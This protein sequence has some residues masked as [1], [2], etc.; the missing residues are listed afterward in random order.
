MGK[1]LMFRKTLVSQCWLILC[2]LIFS[3]SSLGEMVELSSTRLD[4]I[5]SK[6]IIYSE[7]GMSN[8]VIL[9]EAI[10]STDT[11]ES[12][13]FAHISIVID[14]LGSNWGRTN[15]FIEF[16]GL[17]TLSFL[18]E[19]HNLSSQVDLALAKGHEVIAHVPM[20]PLGI[21][22]PGPRALMT[23]Y[24]VEDI[25]FYL[26]NHL[27]G[28][29]GYTGINNHMGSKF[30]GNWQAMKVLMFELQERKLFWLDS[31]THSSSVGT[32]VA[33]EVGV[34]SVAR[35]IFIDNELSRVSILNQLA[36]LE[37]KALERGYAIGIGHPN[38]I[39]Y[40]TLSEWVMYI[41]KRAIK[42]VRIS[43]I[44]ENKTNTKRY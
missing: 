16:D 25:R 23:D 43:D 31:M 40:Q 4:K 35:D 33:A 17:L 18:P 44:I 26:S 22:D 9:N 14:D 30:T 27:D 10:T 19:S 13:G 39:T 41:K 3:P 6:N 38:L 32:K 21:S 11:H 42:L 24:N 12:D 7:L 36:L 37:K 5:L 34:N 28:W 2:C 15:L 8:S 20:E 29:S 1:G